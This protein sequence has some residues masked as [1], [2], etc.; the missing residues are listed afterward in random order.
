MK[1]SNSPAAAAAANEVPSAIPESLDMHELE[2][3]VGYN[4]RR[5]W[6]VDSQAFA[7]RMAGYGL[8]QADFSVLFLLARN[9][10]ATS[11]QLCTMLD[12]QPPNLVRL[13]SALD[14]RGLLKRKAHPLD[15][16]A[17]GLYL[18][19]AGDRLLRQV[20]PIVLQL[21]AEFYAVL[22]PDEHKTLVTLLQKVY[23]R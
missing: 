3:F 12:I 11:R 19:P 9:P 7:E 1:K 6:L 17:I 4:V 14:A 8:K 23:R 22:S 13:I 16:R 20:E 21:E 2:N 5:T 15:G 18:S 10:G